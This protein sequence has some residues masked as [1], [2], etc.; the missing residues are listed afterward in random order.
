MWWCGIPI[1]KEGTMVRG[2][3]NPRRNL[4]LVYHM[5]GTALKLHKLMDMVSSPW[6]LLVMPV[7][8][9]VEQSRGFDH[10]WCNGGSRRWWAPNG[11]LTRVDDVE[12]KPDFGQFHCWN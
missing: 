7:S 12:D 2:V 9:A 8:G 6:V 10:W 3:Y 11:W 1:S 4:L 5:G